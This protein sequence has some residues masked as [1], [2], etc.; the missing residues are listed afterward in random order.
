M[1]YVLDPSYVDPALDSRSASFENP[2]GGRGM[3][4][5]AHG[6]RKG[7]ASRVLNPGERVVLA[8]VEWPGTIRHIWM[9]FS[10]AVPE[11]LRARV[12][13]FFR[14]ES[15]FPPE[16]RLLIRIGQ[17]PRFGREA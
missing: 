2:T 12:T 16:V 5:M 11:V 8:D 14:H 4:G 3:G 17:N 6:G 15:P 13:A 7:A 9:G 1:N 10:P